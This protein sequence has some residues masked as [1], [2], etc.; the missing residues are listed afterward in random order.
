[1]IYNIRI[2]RKIIC[3]VFILTMVE[4]VLAVTGADVVVSVGRL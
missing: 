1:M 3:I 4:G 2:I